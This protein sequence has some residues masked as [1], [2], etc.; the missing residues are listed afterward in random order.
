MLTSEYT[1]LIF[2]LL[3][4]LSSGR[5]YLHTDP[6]VGVP[7]FGVLRGSR[8]RFILTHTLLA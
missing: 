6:R 2:L 1:L 4:V 7:R 8:Y 3:A 5:A